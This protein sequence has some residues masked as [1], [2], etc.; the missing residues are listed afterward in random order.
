MKDYLLREKELELVDVLGEK[1]EKKSSR[2]TELNK[3]MSLGHSA[4]LWVNFKVD[5]REI[6]GT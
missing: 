2:E 3:I 1:Q 6:K 5:D 4:V